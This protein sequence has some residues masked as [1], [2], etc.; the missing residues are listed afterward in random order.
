MRMRLYRFLLS[1]YRDA[2]WRADEPSTT[3]DDTLADVARGDTTTLLDVRLD[4]KP[5]KTP[6]KMQAVLKSVS[7]AQDHPAKAGPISQGS[8]SE[9]WVVALPAR[10]EKLERADCQELLRQHGIASKWTLQGEIKVRE[11]DLDRT[12][13][14]IRSFREVLSVNPPESPG[15]PKGKGEAVSPWPVGVA[16]IFIAPIGAVLAVLVTECTLAGAR[17]SLLTGNEA[18]SLLAVGYFVSLEVSILW[19]FSREVRRKI[20]E[21]KARK[22]VENRNQKELHLSERLAN[23]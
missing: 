1:C 19:I 5:A 12:L 3:T 23:D 16:A 13:Q 8:A 11:F 18:A 7:A 4:G 17:M 6:G 9:A 22:L 14:L 20:V 21:R 10:E 15:M 2:D